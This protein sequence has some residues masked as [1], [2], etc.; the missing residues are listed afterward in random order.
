MNILPCLYSDF[1]RL[2]HFVHLG[3]CFADPR[4]PLQP[5]VGSVCMRVHTATLTANVYRCMCTCVAM[6]QQ[7]LN[8]D[9]SKP[10]P[11]LLPSAGQQQQLQQLSIDPPATNPHQGPTQTSSFIVG[12][13]CAVLVASS[14]PSAVKL[15]PDSKFWIHTP[16]YQL[17]LSGLVE[18]KP[19]MPL[20]FATLLT[21]AGN[22]VGL[23]LSVVDS[24]VHGRDDPDMVL[25]AGLQ[26]L[27]GEG[28]Q[29]GR[30]MFQTAATASAS[31]AA[32]S[33]SAPAGGWLAFAP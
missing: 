24:M 8:L 3:P 12:M 10:G 30:Q 29:E 17:P 33:A 16:F 13:T 25:P 7:S 31:P 6:A 9:S 14:R 5:K 22:E 15:E 26:H 1:Q 11:S 19:A 4:A 2:P 18:G 21:Q 28:E 27:P 20:I 23:Q 32:V